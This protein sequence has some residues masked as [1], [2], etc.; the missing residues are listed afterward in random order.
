MASPSPT[1]R[2]RRVAALVATCLPWLV[3]DGNARADEKAAC[4]EAHEHGQELRLANRWLQARQLFL[5]CA[6]RSCPPLVINDCTRWADELSQQT[7]SIVVSAKRPDGTDADDVTLFV[8]GAKYGARLPFVPIPLDPGEHV[9]RLEQTGSP[10]VERRVTL[11]DGE[12]DRRVE[13]LLG[14][15]ATPGAGA[16][17]PRASVASPPPVAAYVATGIGVATTI[18][19][20][21]FLA[22]GKGKEHDLA[23]SPCGRAGTC[24]DAE[25][26]P[27]RVDYIVSG[28]TAGVAAVAVAIAVWQ[29]VAHGSK[30]TGALAWGSPFT[31]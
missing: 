27:I 24:T 10:G 13:V 18:S 17:L 26:D 19:S 23:T 15:S 3:A 25:V 20:V 12:R 1:Q 22:I 14:R 29:F 4:I 8:D 9:L 28:I 31:F 6:R 7:P 30:S 5:A 16:E 11:H 2:A 21:M